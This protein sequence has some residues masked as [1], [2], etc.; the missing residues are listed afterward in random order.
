MTTL[1]RQKSTPKSENA[2]AN[3]PAA[4]S[5]MS[6]TEVASFNHAQR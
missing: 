6:R 4:V 5:R 3:S 1:T 2:S